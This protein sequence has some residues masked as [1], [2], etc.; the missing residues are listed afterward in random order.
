MRE[1]I[2]KHSLALRSYPGHTEGGK[3]PLVDSK[4]PLATCPHKLGALP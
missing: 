4:P 2:Y 1:T 3:F